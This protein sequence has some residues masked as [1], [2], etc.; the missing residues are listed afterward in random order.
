[1]QT[2]V[3]KVISLLLKYAVQVCHSFPS[4]EQASFNFI[5]AVI[6]WVILESKKIKS[7]TP[8]TFPP[9]IYCEV[10]GP[11]AMILVF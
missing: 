5:A 11:D 9:S 4:K 3:G 8:S 10:M 6:V 2:F 7:V 1:M